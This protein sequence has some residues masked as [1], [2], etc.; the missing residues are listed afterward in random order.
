[1]EIYVGDISKKITKE[2]LQI[3]FEKW[4]TVSLIKFKRDLFSGESKGYAFVN[5][6]IRSEAKKAIEKLNGKKVKGQE[7]IVKEARSHDRDWNQK[8]GKKQGRPF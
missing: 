2:E 5:M 6:P 7:L 1:M 8:G 3:L 4:G